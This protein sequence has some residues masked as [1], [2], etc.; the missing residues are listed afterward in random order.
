MLNGMNLADEKAL[1]ALQ[2]LIEGNS[3][4]STE[5]ITGVAIN[6]LMKLSGKG[7]REV[8]NAH[9][10]SPNPAG[11]FVLSCVHARFDCLL[12]GFRNPRARFRH[13]PS[14]LPFP[15]TQAKRQIGLPSGS[16]WAAR[17]V[18]AFPNA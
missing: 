9:S 2:L 17:Q 16:A 6:A 4:R 10:P 3:L 5:R 11:P 7:W 15:D 18:P 8:R 14:E 12:R 13:S 1:P